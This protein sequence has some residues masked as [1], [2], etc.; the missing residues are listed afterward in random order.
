MKIVVSCSSPIDIGS[1]ILTYCKNLTLALK[2]LSHDV[3]FISPKSKSNNWFLNNNIEF[4]EYDSGSTEVEILLDLDT[5]IQQLR[6][7]LVINNDNCFIQQLAPRITCYFIAIGHLANY[8]IGSLLKINSEYVDK[9]IAISTD[10]KLDFVKKYKLNSNKIKVVYNG[11]HSPALQDLSKKYL[12]VSK[13]K[14]LIGA[15]FSKRKGADKLIKL[16]GNNFNNIEFHW[17]AGYLPASVKNKLNHPS[18][19]LYDRL[20]KDEFSQ[21]LSESHIILMPSR[22]EGCPMLLLEALSNGI[23]PIVSDGIGSMKEIIKHGKNGY[24]CSLDKWEDEAKSI[25]LEPFLLDE[26]KIKSIAAKKLFD[27]SFS[28][29]EFATELLDFKPTKNKCTKNEIEVYKWHRNGRVKGR[30][31][32]SLLNLIRYRLGFIQKIGKLNFLNERV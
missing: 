12:S 16:L 26:L 15:E 23:V 11:L 1:G 7:D 19:H 27:D 2:G 32:V 21:L 13:I 25:L 5:L 31:F 3:V 28:K 30:L 18:V 14:V 29:S 4:Y 20:A 24:V 9:Y 17:T 8:T 10:M 6:P 22:E